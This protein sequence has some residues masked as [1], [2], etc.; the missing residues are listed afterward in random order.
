MGHYMD[1]EIRDKILKDSQ[2]RKFKAYGFFKNLKFF[3]PFLLIF[4]LSNQLTL[5]QIGLLI[6]IREVIVNL[7]EIPSGFIADYFG[8]KIELYICFIFYILSFILFFFTKGFGIA[9]VAMI[10]YGLGEAFR[11]GSHK[12]M[13]YKYLDIKGW[14]KYKTFVYGQTRGT[15]LIG[16][17][18]SSLFAIVL[19]LNSPSMNY[20]FLASIIP[21]ILD[22]LLI[23][24][25]PSSI[26]SKLKE[27]SDTKFISTI[28]SMLKNIFRRKNLRKLVLANS[29]FEAA[30]VSVKDYIQPILQSII[31]SSSLISL[32]KY[33]D[34]DRI[35]IILGITYT[36]IYLISSLGSKS[37]YKAEKFF[38][39]QSSLNVLY[40][41]IPILLIA[42]SLSL[43][44]TY[45]II[46]IFVLMYFIRDI[47]K[48]IF[49]DLVD[50]N[51]EK[52][53][54][55]TVISI[56]SQIKSA[57]T[58]ILAPLM[59]YIADNKGLKYSM[60]ALSLIL[61]IAFFSTLL[62]NKKTDHI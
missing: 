4:L 39:R 2:I 3:E 27:N 35:V 26:D 59:G 7:F 18:I 62:I 44:N 24:S 31:I 10:A 34:K 38:S 30:I 22:L 36:I 37:A 33:S 58:V 41:L 55:A 50:D 19:V 51:M 11:S 1:R 48:P 29:I 32:L 6:S 40:I 25:Y 17:A 61:M 43:H 14:S 28:T 57:A 42:L 45:I 52:S 56:V 13:I 49:V 8:K 20:I 60:L 47:R 21:Y 23:I 15:S 9:A 46:L 53:E 54:R 5:L 16:S 12:A